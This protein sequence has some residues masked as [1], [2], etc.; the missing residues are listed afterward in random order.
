MKKKSLVILHIP[1]PEG[2]RG[3]AREGPQPAGRR[4]HLEQAQLW[5]AVEV[6]PLGM[7]GHQ[8]AQLQVETEMV[9]E[10]EKVAQQF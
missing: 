2:Q 1:R 3:P 7:S 4:V 8:Q 5:S 10:E 6:A 9:V